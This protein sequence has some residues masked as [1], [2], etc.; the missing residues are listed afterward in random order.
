[1]YFYCHIWTASQWKWSHQKSV[2]ASTLASKVKWVLEWFNS[3]R[4]VWTQLK[5]YELEHINSCHAPL[6]I[7][8]CTDG[9]SLGSSGICSTVKLINDCLSGMK[10]S[11]YR[12][13]QIQYKTNLFPTQCIQNLQ[14]CLLL[15]TEFQD[16]KG[17]ISIDILTRVSDQNCWLYDYLWNINMK[18]DSCVFHSIWNLKSI[19]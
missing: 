17:R 11:N 10:H 1:M 16:T 2:S 15:V 3:W 6:G 12:I 7:N 19:N 8:Q 4:L 18:N 14:W 13:Q 9:A 5:N